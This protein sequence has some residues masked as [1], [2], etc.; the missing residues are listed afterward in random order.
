MLILGGAMTMPLPL[1]A[2]QKAMPVIGWLSVGSPRTDEPF[3]LPAFRRGLSEKGYDEGRNVAIEYCW[4][5]GEYN[6]LPNLAA[7]WFVVRSLQLLLR[8]HLQHSP[9]RRQPLQ[10]PSSSTRALTPFSLAW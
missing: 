3:R 9:A 6:R 8:A 1:R 4:A 5:E 7:D 2:Q 10:F